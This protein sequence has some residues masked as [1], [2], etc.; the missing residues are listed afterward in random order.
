MGGALRVEEGTTRR[1][2]AGRRPRQERLRSD[3]R[4]PRSERELCDVTS[5]RWPYHR[6]SERPAGDEPHP[7]L[8]GR[9]LVH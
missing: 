6:S 4:E 8:G 9:E 7:R 3:S 1:A 2:D 5:C